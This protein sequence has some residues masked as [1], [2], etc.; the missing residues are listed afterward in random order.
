M[1]SSRRSSVAVVIMEITETFYA[2]DRAAWRAW[3]EANHTTAKEIWLLTYDKATGKPSV[4]YIDSVEEA[5]CFGWID[6]IAKRYDGERKAQRFTPRRPKGNWTELNKERV[7]RLI[8][9]GLMT[10][11][12]LA[13]APDLSLESFR[14]ADDILAALQADEEIWAN[15]LAFPPLYQR[16]RVGYIEEQRKK[17]PAEFQKRLQSF[18]QKTKQNK[19]FGGMV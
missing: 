9:Q 4:P 12:G 15:F 14:I 5:L 2:P 11:A 18:L 19:M 17:N 1:T 7:R 8:D 16:I 10:E 3:L 6:G 13:V